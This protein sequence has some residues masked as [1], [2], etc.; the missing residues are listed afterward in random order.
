MSS[1]ISQADCRENP[2]EKVVDPPEG[3]WGWVVCFGSFWIHGVVFGLINS[4]GV[5][6]VEIL[7]LTDDKEH[8]ASYASLVGSICIGATF[9]LSAVSS[10]LTDRF[11]VRPTVV[12]GGILATAAVLISSWMHM[13]ELLWLT[14]GLLFGVGA[15]LAYTPSLA[16]L[17]H[18]FK[19]RV[20][21]VNGIATAGSS[22]FT[23][24]L[25]NLLSLTLR[26]IKLSHTLQVMA[27]LMSTVILCGFTFK[28]PPGTR[29]HI[30]VDHKTRGSCFGLL[31]KAIWRNRKYVLWVTAVP[32]ALFGYFV[33]YVH[34]VKHVR[35]TLPGANGE[36]L[37]ACIGV[38]SGIGRII[39]GKLADIPEIN[40]IVL[41][42]VSFLCIGALTMFI[43]VADTF[44]SLVFICLLMG[45]FDG[46]FIS[47]IAPVA[48]DLVGPKGCTQAIGF[49][50]GIC[51]LPL[52]VG[53]PVAGMLYDRLGNYKIAFLAA[54]VPPILASA[55]MCF[56]HKYR[57]E[58]YKS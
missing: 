41:Q 42:Q 30:P 24:A 40:P 57:G 53:P 28:S 50:L 2:E 16:V 56:I 18:Y 51:A 46:C 4:F 22:V 45:L 37:L 26:A 14:Y 39:F 9:F 36:Q 38:S 11:G 27:A 47:L 5:L 23:V 8:A 58:S 44:L 34:I 33:P 12:A 20:G 29:R 31:N 25:P 19:R 3:G 1:A 35:D 48:L 49:L 32:F 55:F 43:V 10:M 52:T 13:V 17:S 21:L 6:Y 7:N 54:G 15:S